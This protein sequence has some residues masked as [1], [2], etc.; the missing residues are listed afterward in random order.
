MSV[1]EEPERALA[2]L[3]GLEGRRSRYGLGLAYFTGG[4]EIAHFHGETRMDVRL[5]K[6]V[7]DRWRRTSACSSRGASISTYEALPSRACCRTRWAYRRF[8]P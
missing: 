8:S 5:T 3:P 4:R 7:S 1:K 2:F 6:E